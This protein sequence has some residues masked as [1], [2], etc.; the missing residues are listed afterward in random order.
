MS[1]F[2]KDEKELEV[3]KFF[4]NRYNNKYWTN[5]IVEK[6]PNIHSK[7]DCFMKSENKEVWLQVTTYDTE[8]YKALARCWRN[9]WKITV[10]DGPNLKHIIEA[11]ERKNKWW[12][13]NNLL[14]IR[15]NILTWF[16]NR[17]LKDEIKE[18]INNSNYKKIYIIQLPN[19][20]NIT[21]YNTY[22]EWDILELK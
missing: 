10:Y 20:E 14:L 19:K 7:I 17:R 1:I 8:R 12:K 6:E 16:N 9:P 22:S 13:N 18:I 15:S 21:P 5:Y 3:S 2:N 11:I 4:C